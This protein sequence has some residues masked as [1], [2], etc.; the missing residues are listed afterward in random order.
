MRRRADAGR[1][2]V[3]F[4]RIGLR[5]GDEFRDGTC[6]KREIH[7]HHQRRAD[8]TRNRGDVADEIVIE[9]LVKRCIDRVRNGEHDER[10]AV[11][12]RAD[13]DFGGDIAGGA[14]PVLD[15][16][17]LSEPL[18]Q[19]LADEAREDVVCA[20]GWKSV[21]QAHRPARIGLCR[22]KPR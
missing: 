3:D 4:A 22:G 11:R 17:W 10:V 18:G 5:I 1:S 16:E 14:G 6:R 8:D 2:H 20:A 7:V 15:D 21:N 19:P 12:R 9:L 13:G